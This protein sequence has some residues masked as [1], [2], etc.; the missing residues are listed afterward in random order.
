MFAYRIKL[1]RAKKEML[2]KELKKAENKGDL[3]SVKRY[4]G[5]LMYFEDN[6][7]K[8]DIASIL[9][10]SVQ[11]I[12]NWLIRFIVGGA[13]ALQ[14]NKIPGRPPKLSKKQRKELS[15][16]IDAGPQA[17]GFESGC[18]RSPMIQ[19]LILDKF[20]IYYSVQ[21]LSQLLKDMGYSYQKAR[22]VAAN[23][24]EEK[25]AKW[26]KTTWKNILKRSKE[27]NAYILFGDECSF[28]QWGS[29][30]YTWAKRGKQPTIQTSGNR[31]G[32]KVFGLIDY[33][34][35]R[36][37]S[38]GIEGKLNGE[39]YVDF[40]SGVLSKT[41]KHLILIQDGA[42]Y[43]KGSVVKEFF[44]T[45]QD[46]I[47]VFTLPSYSPDYNPIEMLWKK[48]KEK[49]THLIYFPTFES[50]KNKVNEMLVKF[51]DTPRE[52]LSLFGLYEVK[53]I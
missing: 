4:L 2:R 18:W 10:V 52:I 31:K 38:K 32:Y 37:F 35:G 16:L 40:L 36:F 26:L 53:T 29:L 46:R 15:K 13:K 5:L 21:Y 8:N 44:K 9:G 19:N 3:K 39:S 45:H 7:S 24:D 51:N 23:Q 43:H 27:K 30:S 34:T 22:F 1:S 20:G 47:T 50:L 17:S 41:R 28:P 12:T 11:S 14:T 25:R 42:P 33:F 49:G 48:I 6:R